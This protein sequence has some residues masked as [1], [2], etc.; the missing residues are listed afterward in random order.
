MK[1]VMRCVLSFLVLLML[2]SCGA[3]DVQVIRVKIPADAPDPAKPPEEFFVIGP[4]DS[5]NVVVWQEPTISGLVKVRPDGFITLPLVNEVQVTGMTTG[6]VR[7]TLETRYRAFIKDPFVTIRVQEIASNVIYVIGEVKVPNSY[8]ALG[9]DTILQMLTRA[10][11]LTIF[12][13]R[14]N[15]RVIR[16][17]GESATTYIIDYDAIVKKGDFRHDILLFPGDRV[18]VP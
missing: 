12:A 2:A 6:R 4:G 11:G 7:T 1:Q 13:K 16:R 15:I 17:N 8:P 18:I 9:R 14:N 3:K 10:G 5:L